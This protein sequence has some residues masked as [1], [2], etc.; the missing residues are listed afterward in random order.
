M[1]PTEPNPAMGLYSLGLVRTV[2]QDSPHK[3]FIGGLPCDWTEDQVKEM[4]VP[5][6]ILRAFNL[7]MDRATGN[8][9]GYAFCE[10]ADVAAT[11]AIIQSIHGK[12]VGN[13][14]LTGRWLHL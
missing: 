5:F 14:F 2:V 10:L 4:L 12:P 8:S 9:K 1:G 6:G 7:V 3:L 13:K 11:D